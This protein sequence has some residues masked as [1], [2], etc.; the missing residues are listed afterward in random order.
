MLALSVKLKMVSHLFGA[1]L[2]LCQ[3]TADVTHPCNYT[4]WVGHVVDLNST[5]FCQFSLVILSSCMC[6]TC[7]IIYVFVRIRV[8]RLLFTNLS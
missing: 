2:F 7:K 5:N 1:F 4:T 8:A 6:A 3:M